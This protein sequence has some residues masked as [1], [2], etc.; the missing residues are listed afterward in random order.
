MLFISDSNS[1]SISPD[2]FLFT[3][4][5]FHG[6]ESPYVMKARPGKKGMIFNNINYGPT[7]DVD[8]V[9]TGQNGTSNLGSTYFGRSPQDRQGRRKNTY[10]AGSSEFVLSELEV[11]YS[12][13]FCLH[14]LL[15]YL[16]V[17]LNL[18]AFN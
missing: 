8:L 12:G 5:N 15:K 13:R 4:R 10:L 16:L 7:F 17:I 6:S 11:Y 3:M 9:L 14:F 2:S 18:A 1:S